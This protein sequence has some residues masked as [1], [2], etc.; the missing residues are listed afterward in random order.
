MKFSS[1]PANN[2]DYCSAERTARRNSA[3]VASLRSEAGSE[4]LREPRRFQQILMDW[5]SA[6]RTGVVQTRQARMP[7]L[8]FGTG[9]GEWR[10]RV[11]MGFDLGAWT[12]YSFSVNAVEFTTEPSGA[13]VLPIPGEVAAGLA[14][15]IRE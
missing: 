15:R 14:E 11:R 1:Q 3:F 13:W 5:K 6:V 10:H 12:A 4:N 8:H 9:P 7:A 2:L